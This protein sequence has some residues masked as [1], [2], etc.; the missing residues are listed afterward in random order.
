MS[1]AFSA[2]LLLLLLGFSFHAHGSRAFG[3][4]VD[5]HSITKDSDEKLN[6]DARVSTPFSMPNDVT[7]A[8]NVKQGDDPTVE[9][10]SDDHN[11]D[12]DDEV[13]DS[14][15][16]RVPHRKKGEPEPWFNLDYLPPKMHP[17]AHN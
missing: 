15:R 17:P 2:L 3:F 1:I 16:W 12:G 5:R 10:E 13:V 11:L 14:V 8:E 6:S 4:V 9:I 7:R